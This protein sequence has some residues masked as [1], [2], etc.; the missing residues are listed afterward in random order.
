MS[1]IYNPISGEIA[2]VV[3][4]SNN[5]DV[6]IQIIN[7]QYTGDRDVLSDA[8]YRRVWELLIVE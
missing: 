1:K 3:S 5:G 8:A 7:G 4:K 2:E 6:V